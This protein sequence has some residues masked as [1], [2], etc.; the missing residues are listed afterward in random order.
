MKPGPPSALSRASLETDGDLE[1]CKR[2]WLHTNGAGAYAM[3]TLAL[4]HT[5]REHGLLV[6]SLDPPNRRVVVLSH[7]ETTLTVGTKRHRLS[8]HRFPGVAPTP[9]YRSLVRYDQDPIPRWTY[10]LGKHV[11]QRQLC[12][13]RGKNALVVRYDWF[14]KSPVQ[15]SLMPLLS[16]RPTG[17][18]MRE[19]GAMV[20]R[21]ALR[22]GAVEVQP[23]RE[24]PPVHFRHDGMF[25]G[26]PD[27]WRRFE[28]SVDRAQDR[29]FEEDLWTPGTFE[30]QLEPGKPCYLVTALEE[31]PRAQPAAL[32]LETIEA[33]GKA[34]PGRQYARPVRVACV[35]AHEYV[36]QGT[37]NE[38]FLVAGYP[39]LGVP[40]RDHLLAVPAFCL[41]GDSAGIAWQLLATCC[42]RQRA[43]LLPLNL[44]H[45][46]RTHPSPDAT[47]WLFEAVRA[48]VE[49]EG[50]EHAFVREVLFPA[51]L[52]AYLRLRRRSGPW[53]WTSEEGLLTTVSADGFPLSWMDAY[54]AGKPV[55]VRAGVAVEHQALW[56]RGT[57][58]L[59]ELAAALGHERVAR[60][61]AE[62]SERARVSFQERFWCNETEYPFDCISSVGD[63]AEAWADAT[64]RPNA[65]IALSVAPECF[66]S[67]QTRAILERVEQSLLTP[68][69]LRTLA[70]SDERYQAVCEGNSDTRAAALHQGTAWT[71]LLGTYVRTAAREDAMDET[72][73]W[74]LLEAGP[75]DSQVLGHLGQVA[76]G[77]PPHRERGCPAQAWSQTELLRALMC[78]EMSRAGDGGD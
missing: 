37:K 24:L 36:A 71:H 58:F 19:H 74:E 75:L 29:A 47:L 27:W 40:T 14:G 31:M 61:A 2:E 20:Q 16:M 67:W 73:L 15:L 62:S 39:D 66:E 28:Y 64:I 69:G 34:D 18:L 7:A 35:G 10:R 56:V 68:R 51:L 21:V 32:M 52:R 54:S 45:A 12:L 4:M 23:V 76:D 72:R 25:M 43:G 41:F 53:V 11:L 59:S 33:L 78:L 26:S 5:R 6:A 77:E 49:R 22:A 30:L 3:S 13:V 63:A 70:P 60:Q 48:F 8:T 1:R 38:T 17:E 65:L 57:G 44:K 9:G 42:R 55:T 50:P 46:D